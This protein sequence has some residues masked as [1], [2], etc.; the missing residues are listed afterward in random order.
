MLR[1]EKK[2]KQFCFRPP[3]FAIMVPFES[4]LNGTEDLQVQKISDFQMILT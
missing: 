4:V 2:I 3:I 1:S